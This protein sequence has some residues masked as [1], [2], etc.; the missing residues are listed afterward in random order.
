MMPTSHQQGQELMEKTIARLLL[1]DYLC[2]CPYEIEA[3]RQTVTKNPFWKAVVKCS[4]IHLMPAEPAF[5]E[6]IKDSSL[7]RQNI[8]EWRDFGEK[9]DRID[10]ENVHTASFREEMEQDDEM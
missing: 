5:D 6:V 10:C 9:M 2:S 3:F 7:W 1:S 8:Q 4:M